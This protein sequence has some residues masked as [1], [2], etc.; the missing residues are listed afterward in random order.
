[1]FREIQVLIMLTCII[2]ITTHGNPEG[3]AA[4][5]SNK[6][7]VVSLLESLPFKS[8]VHGGGI[9][10]EVRSRSKFGLVP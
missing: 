6:S 1:M 8:Q 3:N 7:F 4:C 9:V 5:E 2:W 10:A